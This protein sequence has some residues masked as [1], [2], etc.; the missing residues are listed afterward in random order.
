MRLF[1]YYTT[2][3]PPRRAKTFSAPT[4][5]DAAGMCAAVNAFAA[6]C[7]AEVAVIGHDAIPGPR[8]DFGKILDAVAPGD[9][10]A[11]RSFFDV[12]T[13]AP[14][15]WSRLRRL[16][17]AGLRVVVLDVPET[18]PAA[19][20]LVPDFRAAALGD[21]A[22]AVAE[23]TTRASIARRRARQREGVDAARKR[24]AFARPR[25]EEKRA[26]VRDMLATGASIAATHRATGASL[27]LVRAVR[28]EIIAADAAELKG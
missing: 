22:L 5:A 19:D 20:R 21:L 2:N 11:L 14:D 7:G 28:Q 8:R 13:L 9:V 4:P 10:F 6:G 18:H 24:G 1:A 23:A 25:H 26:K 15:E 16:D 17:R 12:V 3:R 27:W